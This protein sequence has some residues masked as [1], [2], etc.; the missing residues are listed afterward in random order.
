[1]HEL[2]NSDSQAMFLNERKQSHCKN[3]NETNIS[4]S[5]L[6][7]CTLKQALLPAKF[8]DELEKSAVCST[9]SIADY[10]LQNK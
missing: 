10:F 1:M 4:L 2:Q 3:R 9:V 8:V 5:R 6:V 7:H